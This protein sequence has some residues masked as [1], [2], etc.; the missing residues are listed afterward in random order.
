MMHCSS[1]EE[2]RRRLSQLCRGSLNYAEEDQCS[3]VRIRYGFWVRVFETVVLDPKR[4]AFYGL[5]CIV[6][7]ALVA[8]IL[9]ARLD[10][11]QL[12]LDVVGLLGLLIAGVV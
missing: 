7:E 2:C 4:R 10:A 9:V 8:P 11:N 6:M 5:G 1:H 12:L 3:L